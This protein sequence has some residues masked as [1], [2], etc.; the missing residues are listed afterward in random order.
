MLARYRSRRQEAESAASILG[1]L[2]GLIEVVPV[3]FATPELAVLLLLLSSFTGNLGWVLYNINEVSLRQAITPAQLLGRT[4]A[5]LSFLVAGMIPLGFLAGGALGELIGMRTT[6]AL[7]ALGS[8]ASTLWLLFSP[9]RGIFRIPEA[10]EE[11]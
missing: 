2:L 6:I 1:A 7:A 9:V 11:A 10:V 8:L 5:T 3:V 4:N